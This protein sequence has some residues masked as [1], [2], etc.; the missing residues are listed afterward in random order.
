MQGLAAFEQNIVGHVHDIGNGAHAHGM[1]AMA[2]AHGRRGHL[3]LGNDPARI[4]PAKLGLRNLNRDDGFRAVGVQ[5][6]G[7]FRDAQGQVEGQ[8]RLTRQAQH[9]EAVRAVGRDGDVQHFPVQFEHIHKPR[10]HCGGVRQDHDAAVILGE[11]Q[12][13]LGADH[14]EGR[15]AAQFGFLD[16]RAVRQA[17]AHQ[18]HGHLLAGGH[19]GRAADDIQQFALPGIHLAAVQMVGVGVLDAF[20]HVAHHNGADGVVG[21]LD[22]FQLQAKH[23]Q[24]VAQRFGSAFVRR[25][26]TQP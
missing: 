20:R 6:Q 2:H 17:R 18:S 10:A 11:A 25:K 7:Q 22:V 9:G 13:P 15:R 1:Q 14:A 21:A 24:P 19:V 23:G 4:Q 5:V 26:F 16:H 3:D 12:F 8:G